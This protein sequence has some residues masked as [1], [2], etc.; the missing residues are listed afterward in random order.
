M[1]AWERIWL[2]VVVGSALFG[3][4]ARKQ[5]L[6]I[7]RIHGAAPIGGGR[8]VWMQPGVHWGGSRDVTFG[9]RVYV[10]TG[11]VFD[12]CAPIR[13]EDD[14]H[15]AHGVKILTATHEV[16]AG[17]KRAGEMIYGPIRLS[18]GA[19]I[20]ANAVILP[21][22]TV[23]EGCVVAA[24]SVVSRDCEPH[25]FYGGAPATRLRDLPSPEAGLEQAEATSRRDQ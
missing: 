24:G 22:V 4:R 21:G 8:G 18:A 23:G 17:N 5:L 6:R 16:G 15:V 9:D 13:I 11:V 3:T 19:W 7:A 20:G 1:V 12:A 2:N 10:N 25:G 14:V